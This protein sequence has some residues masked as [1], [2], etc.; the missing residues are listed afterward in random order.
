MEWISVEERF[1]RSK[2]T[3]CR[4]M[5]DALLL[6]WPSATPLCFNSYF[7]VAVGRDKCGRRAVTLI[8][9][10]VVPDRDGSW[11]QHTSGIIQVRPSS[12]RRKA[13]DV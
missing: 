1:I 9:W 12:W 6:F 8:S 11:L 5:P 13:V 10:L 2:W 7:P 3:A 4:H